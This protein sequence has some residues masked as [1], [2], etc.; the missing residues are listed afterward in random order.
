MWQYWEMAVGSPSS[1]LPCGALGG[2]SVFVVFVGLVLGVCLQS[3]PAIP[4]TAFYPLRVGLSV[5]QRF[6][7]RIWRKMVK[8][9]RAGFGYK[10]WCDP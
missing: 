7:E 2:L 8:P 3:W 4:R 10:G 9:G 5:I 6:S 1:N